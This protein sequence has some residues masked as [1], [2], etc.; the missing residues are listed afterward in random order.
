MIIAGQFS[1][2]GKKTAATNDGIRLQL[3]RDVDPSFDFDKV[4]KSAVWRKKVPLHL[5]HKRP[6]APP[7]TSNFKAQPRKSNKIETLT[8]DVSYNVRFNLTLPRSHSAHVNPRGGRQSL[9]RKL[10]DAVYDVPDHHVVK[11]PLFR[12]YL[13][14]P[15][16]ANPGGQQ[17]E[18][19]EPLKSSLSRRGSPEFAK[20]LNRKKIELDTYF[21]SGK[22]DVKEI[23]SQRG[24]PPW[25]VESKPKGAHKPP[26]LYQVS[27]PPNF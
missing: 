5:P 23:L 10:S 2:V 27:P 13:S 1:R 20:I 8:A 21:E 6:A 26:Q 17:S 3:G 4:S 16:L 7:G 25:V 22:Y 15:P 12:Q 19:G 18:L 14:R 9:V 11:V 24:I